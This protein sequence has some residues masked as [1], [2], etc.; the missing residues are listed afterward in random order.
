MTIRPP[1]PRVR[2]AAT[3]AR[4]SFDAP[5][6]R[7]EACAIDDDRPATR[8]PDDYRRNVMADGNITKD[9]M[10]GAVAADDFES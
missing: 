9:V 8:G 5:C 7:R 2:G 4:L 1:L 10:Y 6:V 3:A